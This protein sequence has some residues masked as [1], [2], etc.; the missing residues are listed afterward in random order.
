[1]K[2]IEKAE[3]SSFSMLPWDGTEIRQKVIDTCLWMVEKGLTIGTWG[4]ISVRLRDGNIL[5]TP[6]KIPYEYMTPEDMVVIAPDGTIVNGKHIPTSEREIH[7]IIL[8]KR[9]DV[10]AVIHTHSTYAMACCALEKGIPVISEEMAQV[11]AGGIPMTQNFVPSEKHK[12]LG[13]EVGRCIGS[14]NAI[15]IR[16]HGPVSLGRDLEDAKICAQVVEKSS[17]MYLHLSGHNICE[18]EEKWVRAGRQY[19]TNAYGKG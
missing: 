17:K 10:H 19:Y 15:F 9:K 1:M 6:S 2:E 14:A 18:L 3:K 16:N 13:E 8:N 11:L 7:R 12:L 4:N 5:I